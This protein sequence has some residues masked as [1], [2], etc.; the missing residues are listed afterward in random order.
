MKRA[1]EYSIRYRPMTVPGACGV[2][3]LPTGTTLVSTNQRIVE[4]D[5]QGKIIWEKKATGYARRIHR[6]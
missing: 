2:A 1:A 4:L 5:R 6:R 3:R